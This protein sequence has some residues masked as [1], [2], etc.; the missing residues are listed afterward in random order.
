[1]V[2]WMGENGWRGE[3]SGCIGMDVSGCVVSVVFVVGLAHLVRVGCKSSEWVR[4][5][6]VSRRFSAE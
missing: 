2:G 4:I 6:F 3:A 1:M 5:S